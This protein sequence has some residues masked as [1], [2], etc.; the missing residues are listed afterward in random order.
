VEILEG[1]ERPEASIKLRSFLRGRFELV[2]SNGFGTALA[3][4]C[5]AE[6]IPHLWRIGARPSQGIKDFDPATLKSLVAAMSILAY[7]IIVPSHYLAEPF[8]EAAPEKLLVIPNATELGPEPPAPFESDQPVVAMVA[9]FLPQKRHEDFLVAAELILKTLRK[10][11]FI[12]YGQSYDTVES[13]EYESRIRRQAPPQCEFR[14]FTGEAR[15]HLEEVDV[16]VLPSV[17]EGASRAVLEA[18]ACA[19]P[20]VASASGGNLEMVVDGETGYLFT[21]K[22]PSELADKV[23]KIVADPHQGR[24]MGQAGR[25]RV[26]ELFSSRNLDR[27]MAVFE[28]A[29]SSFAERSSLGIPPV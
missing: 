1:F 18:M 7:R 2:Q 15:P 13:R 29:R 5:F 17:E 22:Q 8:K 23:L 26:T 10:A 9:H 3:L 12:I 14:A 25:H 4:A 16:V 27:Y 11:K 6:Q 19:R 20:L 28:G 21:P 24:R